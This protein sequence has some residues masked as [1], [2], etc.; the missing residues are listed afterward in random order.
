MEASRI[1]GRSG[2]SSASGM[3]FPSEEARREHFLKLLAEKLKDPGVPEL[4]GFPQGTD[5]AI[6][7]L[8]DPPYYTACPN[9][10]IGDF[11]RQYGRPYK[12]QRKRIAKS[13]SLLTLAR[14]KTTQSTMPIAIIPKFR[15]RLSCGTSSI[16][17]S[18][19]I[20]CLTVFAGTG[21]TGVAAQLCGDKKAILE[22]LESE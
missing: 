19:A 13:P 9:P 14:E 3:T 12:R 2:R 10:F 1:S 22:F 16:T 6:L 18:R 15:I 5:E 20:L 4:E 17:R 7:A 11:I 21:M 8:S